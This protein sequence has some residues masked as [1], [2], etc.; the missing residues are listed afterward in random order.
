MSTK[1]SYPIDSD[2]NRDSKPSRDEH[3]RAQ[4]CTAPAPW[5]GLVVA[6]VLIMACA[7]AAWLVLK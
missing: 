4:G 2:A 5:Y 7:A 6:L 1:I 3:P